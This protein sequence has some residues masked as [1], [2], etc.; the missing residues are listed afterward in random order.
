[1]RNID[2][3]ISVFI[4]I[5]TTFLAHY[6]GIA[7]FSG[8]RTS[9]YHNLTV[10]QFYTIQHSDN[11]PKLYF[12]EAHSSKSLMPF[13]AVIMEL[14]EEVDDDEVSET[15]TYLK[16]TFHYS[17]LFYLGDKGFFESLTSETF[18]NYIELLSSTSKEVLYLEFQDFR[19]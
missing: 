9:H 16:N 6:S 13:S 11:T 1:M 7:A 18:P 12:T 17:V 3:V 19:I 10:E 14:K 4:V 15:K 5:L 2:K 8:N